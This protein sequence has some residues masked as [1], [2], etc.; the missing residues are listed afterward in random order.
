M[1]ADNKALINLYSREGN[2]GK[3]VFT[4]IS[5]LQIRFKN[6]QILREKYPASGCQFTC[7]YFYGR[8][9]VEYL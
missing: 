7:R 8:L 3:T 5:F 1:I 9:S 4:F 6:P 2:L